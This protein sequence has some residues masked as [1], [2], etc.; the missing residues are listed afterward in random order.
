VCL[1]VSNAFEGSRNAATVVFCEFSWLYVSLK[2][3]HKASAVESLGLKPN[4]LEMSSCCVRN[5]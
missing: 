1:I 5:E 4:W 3:A 2:K